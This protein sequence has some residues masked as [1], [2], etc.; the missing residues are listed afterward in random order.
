MIG[1]IGMIGMIKDQ[2]KDASRLWEMR[3]NIDLK[4]Q[5]RSARATLVPFCATS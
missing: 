5:C 3:A 1:M 2:G 4:H